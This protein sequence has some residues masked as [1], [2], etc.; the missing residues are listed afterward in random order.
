MIMLAFY[1]NMFSTSPFSDL[2]V[3][4]PCVGK[5]FQISPKAFFSFLFNPQISHVLA[6]RGCLVLKHAKCFLA[7]AHAITLW[8][9]LSFSYLLY[10]THFPRLKIL[11]SLFNIPFIP[12]HYSSYHG[13]TFPHIV[14][15]A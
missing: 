14:R 1:S 9:H 12:F 3:Q 6:S 10:L 5:P 13:I 7:L 11:Q 4:I 2:K 15:H 8:K